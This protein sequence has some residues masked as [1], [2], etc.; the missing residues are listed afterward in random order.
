MDEKKPF[1]HKRENG[2]LN[3]YH[4][5]GGF[6]GHAQNEH[7]KTWDAFDQNNTHLGTGDKRECVVL[8]KKAFARKSRV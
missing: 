8:V 2:K 4:K 5:D 7:R 3:V 6:I 1:A